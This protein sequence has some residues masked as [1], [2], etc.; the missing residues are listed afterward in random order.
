MP[1]SDTDFDQHLTTPEAAVAFAKALRAEASAAR[2]RF[3]RFVVAWEARPELWKAWST[4][5]GAFD[6]AHLGS[7]AEYS[8]WKKG[9]ERV[10]SEDVADIIGTHGVRFLGR[11][12]DDQAK[13]CLQK[14]VTTAN[15]EGTALG[16]RNARD[17]ADQFRAERPPK[18][19]APTAVQ[20]RAQVKRLERKVAR[21]EKENEQ[22]RERLGASQ[23]A[24]TS[25]TRKSKN[26]Q[27]STEARQ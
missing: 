10:G 9:A 15:K 16:E 27:P 20:L 6:A 12:D 18:I 1:Q 5:P 3:F 14:M 19:V 25:R 24:G 8:E 2:N 26:N 4:F 22:L 23:K 11:A 7:F 13:E 17:I 21:L